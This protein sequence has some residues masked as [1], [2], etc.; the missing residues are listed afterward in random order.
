LGGPRKSNSLPVLLSYA[1]LIDDIIEEQQHKKVFIEYEG[2]MV[3]V[4]VFRSKLDGSG[5]LF[6][7]DKC[8]ECSGHT[9][10]ELLAGHGLVIE[11]EKPEER[12]QFYRA[13]ATGEAVEFQRVHTQ[14]N[15]IRKCFLLSAKVVYGRVEGMVIPV[16]EPEKECVHC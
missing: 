10:S 7:N 6:V 15:L 4:G 8:V 2:Q 3:E 12:E 9:R 11:W 13:L 1:Q 16:L 14:I 5:F